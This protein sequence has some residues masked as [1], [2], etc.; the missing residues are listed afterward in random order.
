MG[1]TLCPPLF[2]YY[3]HEVENMS[4]K[5]KHEIE[6]FGETRQLRMTMGTL[7]DIEDA[8]FEIRSMID[9]VTAGKTTPL[10]FM[11]WAMLRSGAQPGQ[12]EITMEDLR[13][14]LMPY[15]RVEIM[16]AVLDA[17]R[18]GFVME[19]NRDEVRDPV[20]EEIEK[21]ETPDA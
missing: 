15:Q 16:T 4:E 18:R 17:V 2:Y 3:A 6:L 20:L 13:D 8:G 9:D 14:N 7:A 11:L 12:K 21:K 1:R 19:S 10:L 5:A